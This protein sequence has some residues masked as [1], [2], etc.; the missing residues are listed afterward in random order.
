MKLWVLFFL[1]VATLSA[2][3][4]NA[5]T[6]IQYIGLNFLLL[7]NFGSLLLIVIP[8]WEFLGDTQGD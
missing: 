4:S 5:E 1:G 7:V 6:I 3:L 2:S 8:A